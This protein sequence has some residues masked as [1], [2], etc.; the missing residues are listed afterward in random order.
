[1]FLKRSVNLNEVNENGILAAFI[2]FKSKGSGNKGFNTNSISS[3][4]LSKSE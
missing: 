3:S 2:S 1:M 4:Y